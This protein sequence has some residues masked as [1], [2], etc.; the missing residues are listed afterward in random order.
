MDPKI[1]QFACERDFLF[2]Y[3]NFAALNPIRDKV[4][5]IDRITLDRVNSS[6]S[7]LSLSVS[8]CHY[9]SAQSGSGKGAVPP[10][11]LAY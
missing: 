8:L 6:V 3:E 11:N 10:C 5:Y 7:F 1:K 4:F 2:Y 9:V